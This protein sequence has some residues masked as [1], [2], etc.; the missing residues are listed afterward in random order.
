MA[1]SRSL[2]DAF[3]SKGLLASAWEDFSRCLLSANEHPGAAM[4]VDSRTAELMDEL[5]SGSG[6]AE[7][8]DPYVRELGDPVAAAAGCTRPRVCT[9]RFMRISVCHQSS[10]TAVHRQSKRE[11]VS[12]T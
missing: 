2:P 11:G 8:V 12:P 4:H 6:S 7:V 9:D 1:D 5:D 3:S 10:P